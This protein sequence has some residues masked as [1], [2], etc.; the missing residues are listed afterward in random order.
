[1]ACDIAGFFS[2]LTCLHEPR[3]PASAS[4]NLLILRS[5]DAPGPP[6]QKY[7]TSMSQR[8]GRDDQRPDDLDQTLSDAKFF[9]GL[10][11]IRP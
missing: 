1:L 4:I 7:V 8:G 2:M 5:R 11:G 3:F 6:S 10:A 9:K